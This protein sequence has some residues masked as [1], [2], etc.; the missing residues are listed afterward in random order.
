MRV[1]RFVRL[2]AGTAAAIAL[3]VAIG[4]P[5]SA[6]VERRPPPSVDRTPPSQP[7]GLR[8]IAVTQTSVTLAWNPSTDNVGVVS[9]SLWG[10]GLSGVVSVAHPQTT[11][12]WSGLRPGQTVTF[13]VRAFDARFNGSLDSGPVTVTT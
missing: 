12:T 11:G 9:Y 3:T 13:R 4:A 10:E 5:V 7:T 1:R 6:G 2:G 8:V